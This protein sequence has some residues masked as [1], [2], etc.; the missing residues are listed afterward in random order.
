MPVSFAILRPEPKLFSNIKC[1]SR[2]YHA[3]KFV[4][5]DLLW[6]V[7]RT[8]PSQR[9]ARSF[10]KR[11]NVPEPPKEEAQP[12]LQ[13]NKS[14]QEHQDEQAEMTL[15]LSRR[16]EE[17]ANKVQFVDS[18]FTPQIDHIALIKIQCPL[19][20]LN[21]KYV[22]K[23][24]V[25]LQRLGLM[26]IVVLGNEEWKDMMLEGPR[27]FYKLQQ[28]MIEEAGMVSEAVEKAGGRA[29]PIYNGVFTIK[30]KPLS[31][32]E[33]HDKL[34]TTGNSDLGQISV[35]MNW[36]KSSLKLGQIPLILPIIVDEYSAQHAVKSNTVM[37]ALSD[38][39]SHLLDENSLK[40]LGLELMKIVVIN[41]EGGIPSDERYGSHVFINIQED[42]QKIKES[43]KVNPQWSIT[44]PTGLESL[45][46]MKTCLE[47]LPSTTSGIIV[48]AYASTGLI[49]NLITDK[50]LLS[51]SLPISTSITRST[52]TTVLRA[53]LKVISS[54][55]FAKINL[56]AFRSLIEA[57]FGRK[58]NFEKYISRMEKSLDTIIITGDYQGAAVINMES[59]NTSLIGDV[60][61]LDKFV[62]APSSQGI[63][64]A[65]ILWKQI[66]L[67]YPNLMWRSRD[68]N[69][70]NKWY[71]ER[72]DGNIKV[73]GTHWRMF[74]YGLDGVKR[75][76]EYVN[77][78]KSVPASFMDH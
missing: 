76:N 54:N 68:D 14:N 22:A 2:R 7:L 33:V 57:S 25:N 13:K 11:F 59:A 49:F 15:Q 51:S 62:V 74:W 17:H 29:T 34:Q 71:F 31:A 73:P 75:I 77:I 41:S 16:F 3:S 40:T 12:S 53:G 69:R 24:L 43:Y 35:S 66:Q 6:S 56:P 72:S 37:I 38:A 23:T 4:S 9:E 46:M 50:P 78:A 21:H 63:G 60:P 64:V 61:Y 20:E 1:W 30:N 18:L 48:P 45:E 26:S 67:K 70:V 36:L 27:N 10:V 55:S 28:R 47:R 5:S 32:N 8:I 42:Y 65:D 44:H 52:T 19:T 39:F 58:L